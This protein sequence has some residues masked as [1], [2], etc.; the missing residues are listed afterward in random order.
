MARQLNGGPVRGKVAVM[1]ATAFALSGPFAEAQNSARNIS[2]QIDHEGAKRVVLN[3]NRGSALRWQKL[4]RHVS[5]GQKVWLH[6]ALKLH[7]GADAGYGEDLNFALAQGLI[8]NPVEVLKLSDD[9]FPVEAICSVPLIEPT[10]QQVK[11]WKTRALKAL[12]GVK[13]SRLS[14]KI[15]ACRHL[16]LASD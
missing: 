11:A 1:L 12:E 14:D 15:S 8:H 13:L 7:A 16:L 10:D 6:I 2:A 3:L 5:S 4:L 9:A